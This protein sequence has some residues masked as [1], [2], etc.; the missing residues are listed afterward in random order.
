MASRRPRSS[1][2]SSPLG[3]AI[4]V[5]LDDSPQLRHMK[6]V[7]GAYVYDHRYEAA[8]KTDLLRRAK[9]EFL[10]NGLLRRGGE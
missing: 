10:A 9:R 6:L 1:L 8:M 7:I 5:D 2:S 3:H 4:S